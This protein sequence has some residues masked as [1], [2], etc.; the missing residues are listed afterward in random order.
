MA[1]LK[2]VRKS[3]KYQLPTIEKVL[4]RQYKNEK[5]SFGLKI[6]HIIEWQYADEQKK[7]TGPAWDGQ[8]IPSIHCIRPSSLY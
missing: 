5:D 2:K 3:A 7:L 4:N 6:R 8:E 1:M